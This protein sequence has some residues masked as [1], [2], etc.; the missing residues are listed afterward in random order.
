MTQEKNFD[1]APLSEYRV[2]VTIRNNLILTAI[3]NAGY[4][5]IS[6]FCK[7]S[8]IPP[9]TLNALIAMK[10]PPLMSS[11]EFSKPAKSLMEALCALPTE[12]WTSEQLTMKLKRNTSEMALNL[13]GMQSALGIHADEAMLLLTQSPEEVLDAKDVATLIEE[14]LNTITPKEAKVLRMRFGIGCEEHTLEEV[15]ACLDVGKE[16]V[17]QIEA[18]AMRKLKH[19]SRS[20]SLEQ[21]TERYKPDGISKFKLD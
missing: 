14:T 13:S 3:E 19:P 8:D 5:N 1:H 21:L 18:K 17:R 4:K 9:T 7:G 12:L 6:A 20:E 15:G 16:R 11:G 2:R 10:V